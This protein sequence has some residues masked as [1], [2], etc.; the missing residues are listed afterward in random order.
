MINLRDIRKTYPSPAGAFVALADIN[1]VIQRGEF[2]AIVGQ[3]GSGKSTL[4]NL[5]AGIDHPSSG[6]IVIDGHALHALSEKSLSL[7]RGRSVGIVFQFFQLLPTLTAAENVMLPM[8]FV[9]RWPKNERR[10]RALALLD[11]LGVAE[12]ADKLPSAL[13]GGQQQRV[14][15]A[16]ALANEPA[17]LLA[18]EPTG[19]LDSRTSQ[20]LLALLVDLVHDG[21][22]VVMVTH[23]HAAMRHATRTITLVD[24]RIVENE[25]ACAEPAHV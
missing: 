19:N 15:V 8:D 14:A 2:V 12:Q 20:S 17:I 4:L 11:R 10:A 18:D 7:W 3:S 13:S 5:L 21:Q 23:E 25:S 24:G 9:N 22:T 16:R 6:E 1:L